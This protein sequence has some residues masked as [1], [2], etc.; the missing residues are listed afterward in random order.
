MLRISF[1]CRMAIESFQLTHTYTRRDTCTQLTSI[2]SWAE[3]ETKP[4]QIVGCIVVSQSLGLAHKLLSVSVAVLASGLWPGNT[5]LTKLRTGPKSRQTATVS[6]KE[7][8]AI[9]HENCH[10]LLFVIAVVVVVAAVC[11]LLGDFSFYGNWYCC[12]TCLLPL[13]L[14]CFWAT[15]SANPVM[16]IMLSLLSECNG[17]AHIF[18]YALQPATHYYIIYIYLQTPAFTRAC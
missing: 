8:F 7:Q 6:S 2:V 15:S 17:L 13:L 10:S 5:P 9:N 4:N 18:F 12:D 3:V 1:G 16:Q 11:S 14:F